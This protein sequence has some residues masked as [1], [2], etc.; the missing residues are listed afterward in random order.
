M[1]VNDVLFNSVRALQ[2]VL[3]HYL[4]N[5]ILSMINE[6]WGLHLD[7]ASLT[8]LTAV[9][10]LPLFL[11]MLKKDETCRGVQ[12]KCRLKPWLYAAIPVFAFL[13]NRLLT[14]VINALIRGMEML[15]S[16]QISNELQEG[17]F[18]GDLLIQLVGIGILVPVME[19]VLFRGLVYN[20]FK[21][22]NKE[23]LSAFLGAAVFAVYHGNLRQI[24]FAFPMALIITEVYRRGRTLM[25]PIL[26]H[27]TV[28]VSSVLIT[29]FTQMSR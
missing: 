22:Y 3:I 24:L 10:V 29:W 8:S 13:S 20:R 6:S 14:V 12:E 28:N 2:P 16:M 1:S 15:F 27:V 17:L 9:L 21:D 26:F 25:A 23:W 19:E 4:A 11:S 18:A 5:G 7:A